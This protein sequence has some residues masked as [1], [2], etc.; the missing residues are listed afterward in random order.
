MFHHC[1]G[2]KILFFD[3]EGLNIKTELTILQHIINTTN[4]QKIF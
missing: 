1:Q 4:K 2:S 3:H